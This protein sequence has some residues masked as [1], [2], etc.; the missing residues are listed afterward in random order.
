M[1]LHGPSPLT[2][3]KPRLQKLDA[4]AGRSFQ[5][6]WRCVMPTHLALLEP[7]RECRAAGFDGLQSPSLGPVGNPVS[8]AAGEPAL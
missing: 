1:G 4:L 8:S 2:R 5:S 3:G 7:R 6:G